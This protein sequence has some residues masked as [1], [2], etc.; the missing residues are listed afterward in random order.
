MLASVAAHGIVVRRNADSETQ[1]T[2]VWI[3]RQK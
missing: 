3:S 2:W 1:E